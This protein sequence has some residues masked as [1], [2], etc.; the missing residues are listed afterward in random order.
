M[1]TVRCTR[2][3]SISRIHR[4]E[5]A[6]R[7]AVAS[8]RLFHTEQMYLRVDFMAS[9]APPWHTDSSNL[10]VHRHQIDR[11][12]DTPRQSKKAVFLRHFIKYRSQVPRHRAK[13]VRGSS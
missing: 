1:S 10:N 5:P 7:K 4:D 9:P 2:T 8:P 13:K 6:A 12:E 11:L 3:V